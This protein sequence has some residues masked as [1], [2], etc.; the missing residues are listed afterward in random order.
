[1]VQGNLETGVRHARHDRLHVSK[2]GLTPCF[3]LRKVEC[4]KLLTVPVVCE[5]TNVRLAPRA[6]G[7]KSCARA[8]PAWTQE[9]Q[10]AYSRDLTRSGGLRGPNRR[11]MRAGKRRR[12]GPSSFVLRN[13]NAGKS[14]KSH[15]FS[16]FLLMASPY[17]NIVVEGCCHGGKRR[18]IHFRLPSR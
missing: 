6:S 15:R 1:M 4:G 17:L 12:L 18:A 14:N 9:P 16:T 7:G 10:V 11:R 3:N 5:T 8:R 13:K 2:P